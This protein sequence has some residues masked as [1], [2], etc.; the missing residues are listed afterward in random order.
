MQ[1]VRVPVHGGAVVLIADTFH[2]SLARLTIDERG[3]VKMNDFSFS[4]AEEW[5]PF[6]AIVA[7]VVNIVLRATP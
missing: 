3:A 1:I 6:V 7:F 4:L 5:H 2:D